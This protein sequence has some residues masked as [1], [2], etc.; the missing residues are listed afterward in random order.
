MNQATKLM[1]ELLEDHADS[2]FESLKDLQPFSDGAEKYFCNLVEKKIEDDLLGV[3][4]QEVIHLVD[5]D[6]V[7]QMIMDQNG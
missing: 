7:S 3:L 6:E 1:I 4:L 2:I 5:W